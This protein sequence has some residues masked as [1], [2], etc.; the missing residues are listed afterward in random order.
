MRSTVNTGIL[1]PVEKLSISPDGTSVRVLGLIEKYPNGLIYIL[2]ISG[3][4]QELNM[5][6]NHINLINMGTY[7]IIGEMLRN[8]L[9]VRIIKEV[10]FKKYSLDYYL[11]V[12]PGLLHIGQK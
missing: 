2:G 11:K 3:G 5:N 12:M 10:T 9:C 6:D 8:K 7:M 1:T 4:K